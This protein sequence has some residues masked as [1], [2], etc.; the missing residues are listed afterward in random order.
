MTTLLFTSGPMAGRR[1]E[2]T[3]ELVLGR[4]GV[5][6]I[7][8]DAEVSRRHA[9]VR[10]RRD[11]AEIEDLGSLNGTW[12]NGRRITGPTP[13]ADGDRIR[14]GVTQLQLEVRTGAEAGPPGA[15]VQAGAPPAPAGGGSPRPAPGPAPGQ[16][17]GTALHPEPNRAEGIP[18]GAPGGASSPAALHEPKGAGRDAASGPPSA[19]PPASPTPGPPAPPTP[20]GRSGRRAA[21][22]MEEPPH[23]PLDAPP[24]TALPQGFPAP[25]PPADRS[26]MPQSAAAAAAPPP[27]PPRPGRPAT[28]PRTEPAPPGG[29]TPPSAPDPG[30]AGWFATPSARSSQAPDVSSVPAPPRGEAS[31]A[32]RSAPPEPSAPGNAW[33]SSTSVTYAVVIATALALLVYFLFR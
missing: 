30:D 18:A 4:E 17:S 28:V 3:G 1:I 14:L 26:A 8:E 10:P 33:L 13:I 11:G 23:E 31:A 27:A 29:P 24:G 20:P 16:R 12:V 2:L 32:W 19:A 15:G 5:H 22:P 7:V 9:A 6:L 21:A 25:A